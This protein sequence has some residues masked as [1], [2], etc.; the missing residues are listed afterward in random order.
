MKEKWEMQNLVHAVHL[1][2]RR[3]LQSMTKEYA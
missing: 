1:R 2:H 3:I